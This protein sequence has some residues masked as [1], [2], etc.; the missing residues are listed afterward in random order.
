MMPSGIVDADARQAA[1]MLSRCQSGDDGHVAAPQVFEHPRLVAHVAQHEDGVDMP[2]LE[3]RAEQDGLV[4][5]AMRMT[6]HD[7][8]AVGL[9]PPSSLPR[10]RR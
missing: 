1:W 6:E 8:V 4:S 3:D 2:R 7:V 9:S 10:S 5:A